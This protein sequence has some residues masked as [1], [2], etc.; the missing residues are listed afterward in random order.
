MLKVLLVFGTLDMVGE[1]TLPL[2]FK[3]EGGELAENVLGL[4]EVPPYSWIRL[5]GWTLCECQDWLQT[6]DK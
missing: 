5:W 6:Q 4:E 2:D 1:G 3:V